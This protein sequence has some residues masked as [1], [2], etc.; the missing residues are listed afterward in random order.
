VGTI[1]D[2]DEPGDEPVPVLTIGDRS[3][4]EGDGGTTPLTFT[5]RLSE[6][7]P[8][9]VS[10]GYRVAADTARLEEDVLPA[11]GTVRITAGQTSATV[12]VRIVGDRLHEPSERFLVDLSRP[13]HADLADGRAVG[14]IRDDDPAPVTSIDD[15]SVDEAAG[16]ASVTV[17]LSGP[18]A[19]RVTVRFATTP[20]SASAGSDYATIAGTASFPPGTTTTLVSVPILDDTVDESDETF[21]VELSSPHGASIGDG[22]AEVAIRDDDRAPVISIGDVSG[23]EGTGT[24]RTF[25]FPVR[26]SNPSSSTVRVDVATV[27]GSARP[28][29]DFIAT[30]GT[31]T[32]APGQTTATVMVP[33]VP[34]TI[35]EPDEIFSVVLSN[36][37][38]GTIGDGTGV[39]TIEDDDGSAPRRSTRASASGSMPD[40]VSGGGRRRPMD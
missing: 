4:A 30:S 7:S 26:L 25:S 3:V 13:E 2:D 27:P 22:R 15:V 10:V 31:V 37:V 23:P 1:R 18:S 9:T 33:V 39:G 28:G 32:I 8:E 24:A 12:T 36:P 19:E 21:A 34:D 29:Q 40:R 35:V 16:G 5:V 11:S 14:T 6:P 17:R 38:N 20:G